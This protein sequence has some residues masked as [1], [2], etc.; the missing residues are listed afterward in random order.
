MAYFLGILSAVSGIFPVA[1]ALLNYRNLDRVLK[2]AAAFFIM[3]MASDLI[4]ILS[5]MMGAVNN[6]PIIHINIIL[7][8]LFT[9]AIYY[10]ALVSTPLKRAVIVLVSISLLIVVYCLIFINNIWEYPSTSNTVLSL[11]VI[12]FSIVYFYQLLN[13]QEF[14]HIEKIGLFWINAGLLFYFSINIFLFMLFK[15]IIQVH[16]EEY[17][18]IHNVT[19]T[20]ANILF[21]IGLFCKPQKTS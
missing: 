10:Y 20:I 14:I 13:R 17:Y 18:M 12:V 1:A 21:S 7:S 16:L 4:Q 8:I 3:N 5:M 6:Q 11:L 15:R 2:I 9:G 19:N